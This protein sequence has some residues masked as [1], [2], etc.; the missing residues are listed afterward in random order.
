MKEIWKDIE[1]YEGI[2]K[3]SNDGKIKGLARLIAKNKKGERM[4]KEII[5][6]QTNNRK[7]YPLVGLS[8]KGTKKTLSVH[9]LVA[10]TFIPNPENKPQV[11]H[12][13]GDKTDN[14]VENLEW[15]TGSENIKHAFKNG[16]MTA[17][18]GDN[19]VSSKLTID[20]AKE[21]KY[22][23]KGMSHR[24]IAKIYGIAHVQISSIR[25]GKTWKHI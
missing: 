16:L 10:I 18:S 12:I 7:G 6:V 19:C 24:D 23:H 8:K 20:Q 2:Y 3:V 13:N 21:I 4:L 11:N 17:I 25:L 15:C 14:R 22:G 9:R 5:M 1:G